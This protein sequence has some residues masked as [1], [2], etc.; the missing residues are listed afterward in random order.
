MKQLGNLV[1]ILNQF[2]PTTTAII[3]LALVLAI[4]LALKM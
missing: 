1:S 3:F 2:S 4:I